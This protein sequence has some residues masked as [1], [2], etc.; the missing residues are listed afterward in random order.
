[1][2]LTAWIIFVVLMGGIIFLNIIFFRGTKKSKENQKDS[3]PGITVKKEPWQKR[4]IVNGIIYYTVP[5]IVA[6]G[7]ITILTLK[8]CAA[9]F[10]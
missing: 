2:N 5:W 4:N 8:L 7:V 1:M 3:I 10:A 6:L 9:L